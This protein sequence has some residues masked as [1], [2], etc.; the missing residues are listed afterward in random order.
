MT[1]PPSLAVA[2]P[3]EADAYYEEASEAYQN[4]EYARASDLLE[5]AYAEDPNLIYQYN[6]ILALQAMGKHKQALKV[7]DIYENPMREDGRFDDI[8]EIREEIA[9]ARQKE[10]AGETPKDTEPREIA[11]DEDAE[12]SGEDPQDGDPQDEDQ[13]ADVDTPDEPVEPAD[14]GPSIPGW[15]LVGG[16]AASL[17]MAG[18]FGSTL[19]I[20]D[21]ADRR[22]CLEPAGGFDP[23]CYEADGINGNDEQRAQFAD[24]QNTWQTHQTLTWVFA[25]VG[26]AAL[27]GGGYVLYSD[28]FFTENEPDATASGSEL[29]VTP[30]VG[31]DGAGGVLRL[32]F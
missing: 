22:D 30:Y 1:L 32:S 17:A 12:S 2:G 9:E 5:R 4:G 20:S 24:D 26:I 3:D 23:N 28:G 11:R 18:L 25:G 21:V 13:T 16:G 7:L 15:S 6:R 14:K 27:A 8:V 31:A 19:L 29:S 10:S